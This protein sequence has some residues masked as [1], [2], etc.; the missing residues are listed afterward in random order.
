ML[1]YKDLTI[2]MI[3]KQIPRF[4]QVIKPTQE[5]WAALQYELT[6]YDYFY[7]GFVLDILAL[8]KEGDYKQIQTYFDFVEWL[9]QHSVDDD[10][11]N[12]VQ[13][14]FLEY[15]WESIELYNMAL[16]CSGERT[17][18]LFNNIEAYLGGP[19]RGA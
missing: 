5:S 6:P 19:Y 3:S 9:L 10:I 13:T 2:D 12:L 18:K 8:R 4:R 7:S 15:F 1:T 11:T 14:G 17:K 16:K